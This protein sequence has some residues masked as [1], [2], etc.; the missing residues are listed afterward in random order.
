M[1]GFPDVVA[2]RGIDRIDASPSPSPWHPDL[3]PTDDL[4]SFRTSPEAYDRLVGR[5]GPALAAALVER[6]GVGPGA[7]VLDVGCGPGALALVLSGV[8]GAA[9]LV[10]AVDPSHSYAGACRVRVPGADVR[11]GTAE[12]LPF[13]AAT[14]D[15]VFAQL[16]VN[17]MT[18]AAVGV[19][20]MRRVAR[21]GAVVAATVWDYAGEMRLLRAFWDAAI[22]VAG[23]RVHAL[24][25]GRRMQFCSPG[26]LGRL[27]RDAGLVDVEV[28]PVVVSAAYRD[29]DDL[30]GPLEV[31]VAPSGAFCVS[32]PPE[33]RAALRHRFTERL[34]SPDGPFQLEARAWAVLGRA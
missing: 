17:F 33:R 31:G 4:A 2:P 19:A 8:V 27:W 3:V 18:D 22:D 13:E 16:V 26:E 1:S 30:W 14:F 25:E 5:Y 7:R 11:V 29:F 15:A 20:E 28:S 12:A 9:E 34:G 21:P 6:A 32:L 24:D 23:E 10:A